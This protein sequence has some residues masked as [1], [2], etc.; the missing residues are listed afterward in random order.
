MRPIVRGVA[1][2]LAV[3]AL[4]LSALVATST[5][6]S[7]ATDPAP[8]TAAGSWLGGQLQANGWLLH[9]EEWDYDNYGATIDAA[10]GLEAV[11]A[12]DAVISSISDAVAAQLSSYIGTGTEEYAGATAKAAVL[13][14]LAGDD[15]EA[16]GGVDLIDRLEGL[17][18]ENG[19]I[20]DVSEWGDYE[21]TFG[22]VWAV[23]SLD[24][25]GSA[26]ADSTTDFLLDQQCEAGYFRGDFSA[27][28]AADQTCDGSAGQPSVDAT[29]LAVQSLQSQLDD[30]DVAGPVADAVAWL[31]SVQNPD[32]SF[33]SDEDI[34][35]G[36]ANSTGVA[37]YA[38]LVSGQ[39][40][41]A[42]KAAAW[43]R[44]HQATNVANC[45]YYDEATVG[46]VAY[47][48]AA[49]KAT[50]DGETTPAM[51]DQTLYATAQAL[52]ALLAAPAG[53]ETH[54][55]FT[56]EYVKAGGTKPV[57]VVDAAPGEALCAML[58]EQ[59]VLA[60]ADQSG[61]AKLPVR[62]PAKTAT[63]TV[64]VANAA[65]TVGTVEIN[66]LGKK[67]LTVALKK[68][69]AAGKKQVVK[70]TGLAPG[71]MADVAISWPGSTGSGSGEATA[72]QANGKGVFRATFRVPNKPGKA[73]VKAT[74]EFANRKASSSF[75]VTR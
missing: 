13:A 68:Q 69:V 31:A 32:G 51:R 39:E 23:Q 16:F 57:G 67:K 65:G 8:V 27:I 17:V 10:I 34:P 36:N 52:P 75:T 37:G 25:A 66:A 20:H 44:A 42:A 26:L 1:A 61:E 12:P 72:G 41:A 35:A 73:T 24:A 2:V 60:Y 3:P 50:R 4:S 49:L 33:G 55:L 54:A 43:L 70:V 74:G 46:S 48:G 38:L 40:E 21:S 63:S 7:A 14:Q 19:R 28:D 30:T 47:D 29:A 58:G 6:A 15:P 45:V 64:T 62:I 18:L 22:Q 71:E 56:A 59:S 53:G 11:G 9:N 5:S